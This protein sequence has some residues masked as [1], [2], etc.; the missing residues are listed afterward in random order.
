METR[1]AKKMHL[2]LKEQR[3]DFPDYRKLYGVCVWCGYP[4]GDGFQPYILRAKKVPNWSSM[5]MH[6]WLF[7]RNR[8]LPKS[9][10]FS[11]ENM[12]LLHTS[13]HAKYGQSKAMVKK[14]YEH[15]KKFYNLQKWVDEVV[16]QTNINPINLE[17]SYGGKKDM[18]KSPLFIDVQTVFDE[19]YEDVS[20]GLTELAKNTTPELVKVIAF[21]YGYFNPSGKFLWKC[22]IDSD[23]RPLFPHYLK[24][25]WDAVKGE[26]VNKATGQNVFDGQ[27]KPL[28]AYSFS[29]FTFPVIRAKTMQL[30]IEYRLKCGIRPLH[31]DKAPWK[32]NVL[33]IKYSLGT[34]KSL[35]SIYHTTF[36]KPLEIG[37]M[38]KGSDIPEFYKQKEY[39]KIEQ[40]S[41]SRLQACSELYLAGAGI[42]WP[43]H[44]DIASKQARLKKQVIKN[45][46]DGF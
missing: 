3:Y 6:E 20:K 9:I 13:C 11:L 44:L 28:I 42:Y 17:K 24:K 25:F 35:D 2:L 33:D 39:N 34:D 31:L 32:G 12:V 26:S 23:I 1:A 40:Y 4:G 45:L 30:P 10:T 8:N 38:C 16:A 22:M 37:L 18:I 27:P 36:G 46:P 14:C 15:K 19:R 21:S 43:D 29:G 5:D 7:K 41:I